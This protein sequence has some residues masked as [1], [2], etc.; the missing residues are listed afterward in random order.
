MLTQQYS[1]LSLICQVTHRKSV[2]SQQNI[3]WLNESQNS[4]QKRAA[5]RILRD[6]HTSVLMRVFMIFRDLCGLLPLILCRMLIKQSSFISTAHEKAQ[7]SDVFKPVGKPFLALHF[8]KV[9]LKA[10]QFEVS[11][12]LAASHTAAS[13]AYSHIKNLLPPRPHTQAQH[14]HIHVWI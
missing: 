7:C 8:S 9:T 4:V 1:N 2:C 14:S 12:T 5:V 11:V 13:P 3:L 10:E 6:L